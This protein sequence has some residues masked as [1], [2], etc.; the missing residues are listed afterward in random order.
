VYLF[1]KQALRDLEAMRRVKTWL[2]QGDTLVQAI[3]KAFGMTPVPLTLPDVLPSLQS[4]VIDACYGTPLA[5]LAFQW[6]TKVPY[7]SSFPLTRVMGA[8]VV[9][10]H[11]WDH[12]SAEQQTLVKNMVQ[13]YAAKASHA[14]RRYEQQALPLLQSTGMQTVEIPD[15]EID[16]LRQQSAR[17]YPQLVG[18]L[19]DQNLLD[20][21]L[22]LR[23][24][25]RQSHPS[26]Q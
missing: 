16:Y 21:V 1:S 7:R 4:G 23:D 9:S 12:L 13:T 26:G 18:Q 2:W 8:F 11:Q 5:I 24:Q 20:R 14:I 6:F 10:Q 19:Y 25:Y 3:F 17:L 15:S 22:Q